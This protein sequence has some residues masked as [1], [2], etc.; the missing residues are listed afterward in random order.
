MTKYVLHLLKCTQ[1]SVIDLTNL[2]RSYNWHLGLG[3]CP[4]ALI[5]MALVP[6]F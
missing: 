4:G 2:I 3:I 5:K 6:V 1:A